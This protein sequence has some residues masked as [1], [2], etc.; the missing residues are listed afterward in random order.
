MPQKT[1]LADGFELGEKRIYD[2]K[3]SKDCDG[4]KCCECLGYLQSKFIFRS[5]VDKEKGV[6]SVPLLIFDRETPEKIE[7]HIKKTHIERRIFNEVIPNTIPRKIFVDVDDKKLYLNNTVLANSKNKKYWNEYL[8]KF[9][10]LLATV[11]VNLKETLYETF[12]DEEGMVIFVNDLVLKEDFSIYTSNGWDDAEGRFKASA[13]V[14]LQKYYIKESDDGKLFENAFKAKMLNV[15]N[16]EYDGKMKGQTN[17][18]T[19]LSHKI[20]SNRIKINDNNKKYSK[21]EDSLIT[22]TEGRQLLIKREIEQ[23][24]PERD[25]TLVKAN[26]DIDNL[27][28]LCGSIPEAFNAYKDWS[29]VCHSISDLTNHSREGFKLFDKWSKQHGGDK[30]EGKE[31]CEVEWE[32]FADVNTDVKCLNEFVGAMLKFA[33]K[34]DYLRL[35]RLMFPDEVVRKTVEQLVLK[36]ECEEFKFESHDMIEVREINKKELKNNIYESKEEYSTVAV[37]SPM[38][39]GKTVSLVNGYL[40]PRI[41][42]NDGFRVLWISHRKSFT[43]TTIPTFGGMMKSYEDIE[44]QL[45]DDCLMVQIES[46][47]RIPYL[48]QKFDTVVLDEVIAVFEHMYGMAKINSSTKH[49]FEYIMRNAK[50]LIVMDAQLDDLA[51]KQI[52]NFR[53]L[54]INVIYNKYNATEAK[55]VM[56]DTEKL[57]LM[58]IIKKVKKNKR[59]VITTAIK[60]YANIIIKLLAENDLAEKKVMVYT[61]DTDDT[62]KKKHFKDVNKY[63]SKF[64]VIIYTPTCSEGVSYTNE[65]FDCVFGLFNDKTVGVESSMQMLRRARNISTNKYY[66]YI[67]HNPNDC[68]LIT[69]SNVR[70]AIRYEGRIFYGDNLKYQKEAGLIEQSAD[71][72]VGDGVVYGETSWFKSYVLFCVRRMK[73]QMAFYERFITLAKQS[74]ATIETSKFKINAKTELELKKDVKNIRRDLKEDRREKIAEA[75]DIDV[76]EYNNLRLADKSVDE[77]LQCQKYQLR[78]LGFKGEITAEVLKRFPNNIHSLHNVFS[79]V[80]LNS[81]KKDFYWCRKQYAM[82]FQTYQISSYTMN[83]MFKIYFALHLLK[84]CGFGENKIKSK[85]ITEQ[86]LLDALRSENNLKVL[87]GKHHKSKQLSLMIAFSKKRSFTEEQLKKRDIKGWLQFVN[88][89]LK[90]TFDCSL[91]KIT[92]AGNTYRLVFSDKFGDGANEIPYPKT[93]RVDEEELTVADRK[94]KEHMIAV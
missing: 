42:K 9:K 21:F 41:E 65:R 49:A 92:K 78:K 53:K 37:R 18:R 69:E 38:G 35:R 7:K 66:I 76:I 4:T 58:K 31:R 39:T 20:G 25:Y 77:K 13:H 46:L 14:V 52:L 68:E 87:T 67:K 28:T 80:N 47:C 51:L 10:Y 82:D 27:D 15:E 86:A 63:W 59:I 44:G 40:I 24:E 83:M 89:I 23:V 81:A 1:N 57:I 62:L 3:H 88:S 32:K 79:H 17:L 12:L 30:Y 19:L 16:F 54:K 26:V 90:S 8:E 91:K 75:D 70:K 74:G 60:E 33:D 85:I 2:S 71:G 43:A 45:S 84:T 36:A 72:I 5:S 55:Y 73:S 94:K 6:N 61:S 34:K 56:F 11:I 22:Y 29:F 50:Q 64:D 48:K 93:K